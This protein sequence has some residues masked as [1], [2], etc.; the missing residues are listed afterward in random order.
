MFDLEFAE[1]FV[2]G[3]VCHKACAVRVRQFHPVVII[4]DNARNRIPSAVAHFP[5]LVQGLGLGIIF[6]FL[7]LFL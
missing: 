7:F 4:F 3:E 2:H 1:G 5:A 6:I